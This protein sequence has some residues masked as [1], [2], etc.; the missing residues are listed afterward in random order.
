MKQVIWSKIQPNKVIGKENIW[1]KYCEIFD[2][3]DK[4]DSNSFFQEIEELFK[5]RENPRAESY[6]KDLN[7]KEAKIWHSSEK[8]NLLESKRSLNISIFLKQFRFSPDEIVYHLSKNENQELGL[9]NLEGLLK[10]LPDTNEIEL[11]KVYQGDIEK[12]DVAEKFLYKLIQVENYKLRIESLLLREEFNQQLTYFSK[13]FDSIFKASDTIYS[14]KSLS[15]MMLHICRVGNFLNDVSYYVG[16]I[17]NG[18]K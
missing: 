17:L 18:Y 2:S 3:N 15:C 10:I 9:E 7:L 12:L 11:L 1:T 5:T 8:I 14:C 4:S 6:S 16:S 13:T